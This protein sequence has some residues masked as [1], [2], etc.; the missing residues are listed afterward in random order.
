MSVIKD[1][2]GDFNSPTRFSPTDDHLVLVTQRGSANLLE[3]FVGLLDCARAATSAADFRH[4]LREG[5]FVSNTVRKYWETIFTIIR[6]VEPQ[7]ENDALHARVWQFFRVLHVL[8]LDL[9]TSTRQSEAQLK[10]MLG[11]VAVGSNPV[12]VAQATWDALLKIASEAAPKAASLVGSDLPDSLR[13]GH[14]T[15]GPEDRRLLGMLTQHSDPVLRRVR[16][17]FGENFHLD[18]GSVVQYLKKQLE[19]FQV[20]LV[21]GPAGSGK[22]AI[23]KDAVEIASASHFAFAFRAEEFAH[24]A[25]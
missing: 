13:N 24:P 19:T 15:I 8:N 25:H 4:R 17:V 12:E 18:R 16:N 1:F 21:S 22:S 9:A 14:A 20:V 5:G 2:W 10:S 3:H 6:E 11:H 7:E 23:A